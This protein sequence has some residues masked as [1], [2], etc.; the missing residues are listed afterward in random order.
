VNRLWIR[1]T[2]TS[3]KA[4]IDPRL[5]SSRNLALLLAARIKRSQGKNWG[6][7]R[8]CLRWYF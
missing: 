6:N 4:G 1:D 3:V 8:L 2:A 5:T 7:A